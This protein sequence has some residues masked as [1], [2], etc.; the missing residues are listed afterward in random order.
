MIAARRTWS[1]GEQ[2]VVFFI[3]SYTITLGAT[4]AMTAWPGLRELLRVAQIF[5]PTIAA[6]VLSGMVGG[7]GAVIRLLL[8]L[9]QWRVGV[10]WYVAATA[11]LWMPA[12]IALA[13]LALGNPAPGMAEGTTLWLLLAQ[14]GQTLYAGPIAEEA[15]WRGF[16]LPR[17]QERFGALTSSL[18]LGAL[19]ACWHLPFYAISGGGVGIPFPAYFA[20]VT[21]LTIYITWIYNNTRG[22]LLLC[23]LAHFSFNAAS[24]F[25]PGHLGLLPQ[26]VFNIGASVGLSLVV[27]AIIVYCGPR[28]LVRHTPTSPQA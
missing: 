18:I 28:Y 11:L 5:S 21:V 6:V 19:W 10:R 25:L 1:T 24:A 14:I 20:L 15:G 4:F 8:R 13:Y 23:V 3:L 27:A 12:L 22:S 2:L 16:A 26:M 17:L 9:V 7:R